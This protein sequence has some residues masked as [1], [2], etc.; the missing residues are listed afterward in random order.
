MTCAAWLVQ[1]EAESVLSFDTLAVDGVRAVL[2]RQKWRV[3]PIVIAN[4]YQQNVLL[5]IKK[6]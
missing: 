4:F 2:S 6:T 5:L 3:K 1:G